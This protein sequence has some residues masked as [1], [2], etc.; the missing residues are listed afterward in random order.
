M[1][2]DTSAW[3]EYLRRTESPT[4]LALRAEVEAGRP[5]ATPAAAVMELLAGSRTEPEALKLSQLL[6]RFEVLVPDSAGDFQ[7]AAFIHR[8][9][10]RAGYTI[11]SIVDC[12]VAAAAIQVQRPL[13][14]RNRDFEVIARHTGLELVVPGGS[15]FA[16]PLAG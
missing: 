9:C 7:H 10:R 12:L 14:A 3:V 13:L 15:C 2:V 6:S 1:I 5:I 16:R 8:T 4:H 11:R